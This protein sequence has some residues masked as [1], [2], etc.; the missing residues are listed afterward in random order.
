[1]AD[2]YS[3]VIYSKDMSGKDL[4]KT[5]SD[6]NPAA[7][8]SE[9]KAMAQGLNSLTTNVYQS[10]DRVARENIDT[11]VDKPVRNVRLMYSSNGSSASETL[12]NFPDDGNIPISAINTSNNT[13]QC[14]VLTSVNEDA[15]PQFAIIP[16]TINIFRPDWNQVSWIYNAGFGAFSIVFP[17]IEPVDFSFTV[18]FVETHNFAAYSHTFNLHI[19]QGGE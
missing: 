16:D 7:Q 15:L 12:V 5:I 14:R 8:P 1:M 19:V 11:A 6:V 18:S 9:L 17:S 13:L 2:K 10:A 3:V 4:S